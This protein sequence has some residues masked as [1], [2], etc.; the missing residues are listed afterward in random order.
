MK[1]PQMISWVLLLG[2]LTVAPLT[3][4]ATP[5]NDAKIQSAMSAA[6]LAIAKGATIMDYPTDPAKPLPLPVL[7]QGTNGWT[8]FP[9]MPSSPGN[10]PGCFDQTWMKWI[11]ALVTGTT[12]KITSPGLAYML[13]GG[14]DPSNTDPMAMEPAAG[15]DWITTPPHVM[16]LQPGKLDL[17]LFSTDPKSGGPWVMFAG[18]PFEHIMMPVQVDTK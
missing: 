8:C 12:P 4:A 16:I 2:L 10:D 11:E 17:K 14:S 3:Q 13:Q 18:T 7:R 9:D 5:E 15:E 6:P 1:Y